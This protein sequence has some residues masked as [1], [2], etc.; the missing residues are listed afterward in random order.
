[1]LFIEGLLRVG[2]FAKPLTCII[3]LKT[4][5]SFTRLLLSSSS[6]VVERSRNRLQF[7]KPQFD[8]KVGKIPWRRDRLPT[9]VFFS[10]FGGSDGEESACNAGDLGLIPG[11]GR[12]SGGRHGNL[13]QYSCLENLHEQK[14]LVGY[15]PWGHKESDTTE[16]LSTALYYR[17]F[18]F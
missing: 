15:G 2:H 18:F 7:R 9:P 3:L 6:L 12:S 1:M 13:F 8:S 4:Y 14:S 10:F 16:R 5:K 11:L 17:L